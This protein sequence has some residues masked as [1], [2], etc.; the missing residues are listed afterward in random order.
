MIKISTGND[1]YIMLGTNS[2]LRSANGQGRTPETKP[3]CA[4]QRCLL[5]SG[6]T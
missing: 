5:E 3:S 1:D 2:Q 4:V 6:G